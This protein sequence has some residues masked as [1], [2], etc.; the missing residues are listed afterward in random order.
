[1]RFRM[2]RYHR[3]GWLVAFAVALGATFAVVPSRQARAA[4]P[5]CKLSITPHSSY[6]GRYFVRLDG[7]V[8]FDNGAPSNFYG[9]FWGYGDDS[10]SDDDMFFRNGFYYSSTTGGFAITYEVTGA[11]LNEDWGQDEIFV[12]C[13]IQELGRVHT[14]FT[15]VVKGDF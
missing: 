7:H 9:D 12:K 6:P 3:F 13:R 10:F 15:N 14:F 2:T 5:F 4:A 1:V 8:H 11:D